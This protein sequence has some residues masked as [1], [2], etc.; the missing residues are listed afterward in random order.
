MKRTLGK[1][2]KDHLLL[3]EHEQKWSSTAV[4]TK[5]MHPW[6]NHHLK[7]PRKQQGKGHPKPQEEG[8][9]RGNNVSKRQKE[10]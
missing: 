8:N 4:S 2:M 5:N 1:H 6:A 9:L 3:E 10:N 7:K